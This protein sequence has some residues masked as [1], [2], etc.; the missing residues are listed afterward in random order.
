MCP[1][2]SPGLPLSARLNIASVFL[3]GKACTAE[4]LIFL[5][6]NARLIIVGGLKKKSRS[7]SGA[8]FAA[9]P[10]AARR[11]TPASIW[12]FPK[13][14]CL[15]VVF[16][17]AVLKR[18]TKP[19]PAIPL[20]VSQ[21]APNCTP[22][23]R[24]MKSAGIKEDTDVRGLLR[25]VARLITGFSHG[26]QVRQIPGNFMKFRRDSRLIFRTILGGSEIFPESMLV[27]VCK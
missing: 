12:F 18:N 17:P 8:V 3:K 13:Q 16:I 14:G 25:R 2:L 1:W 21:S 9:V 19:F 20:N 27:N 22:P 10:V 11:K 5:C 15:F 26:S 4:K 7:G 23:G 6:R 24:E